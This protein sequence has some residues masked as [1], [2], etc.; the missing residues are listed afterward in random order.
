VDAAL[1]PTGELRAVAGTPFDFRTPHL[2]GARVD[3]DDEQLRLG[4]G[5]DHSFAIDRGPG[6]EGTVHAARL[7]EPTSGRTLD[8]YT[9]EPAI[10]LYSG[11]ALGQGP[12]RKGGGGPYARRGG[13]ALE[14][15]HFPD[16]PNRPE[17]PSTILRPGEVLRSRSVYRFS[18]T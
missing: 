11:N 1:I 10:Q 13:V 12:S 15:Q 8:I 14:T 18:V 6:A 5:Y 4:D 2:L 17:F 9:T 7:R 16:S 3:V